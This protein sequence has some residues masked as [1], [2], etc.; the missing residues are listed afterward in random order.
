MFSVTHTKRNA[1]YN[2]EIKLNTIFHLSTWQRSEVGILARLWGERHSHISGG[3]CPPTFMEGGLAISI[4]HVHI[5][6]DA[7][8]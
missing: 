3:N 7:A 6:F 4:W 2:K 8:L 5:P 1:N